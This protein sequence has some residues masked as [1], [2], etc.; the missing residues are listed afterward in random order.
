MVA[1]SLRDIR[2]GKKPDQSQHHCCGMALKER[3][4]LGY[5]DLDELVKKPEKLEFV[6]GM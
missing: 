3:L 6:I 5:P 4:G 2:S 1:R